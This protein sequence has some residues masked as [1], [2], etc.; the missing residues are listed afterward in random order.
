MRKEKFLVI[1]LL[2]FLINLA[3]V[4]SQ[5]QEFSYLISNS[6]DWRDVYSVMHYSTLTGVGSD[7][8]ASTRHG[9][10]LLGGIS[11][12]NDIRVISSDSRF[13]INYADQIISEGFR[14][15]DEVVMDNANIELVEDLPEIN[16][17]IVVDNTYG[18][19]AISAAPYAVVKKA[20]VFLA[21]R[22]NIDD[23]DAVLSNRE[24]DE[25]M[26]YGF[27]D[28]E[29]RE[30]LEKYDPVVIDNGDRFEDN[31]EIVKKYLELKPSE[32]VTLSNGEFIEKSLMSGNEPILFTGKENVPEQIGEYIKNSDIK[33]GVLV[34]ADLVGTATNIR[35]T[36]GISVIVKFAR[37]ARSPTGAIAAVEG[38][39]LFYLPIPVVK[40]ELH[41]A[42]Y[43]RATSQLELTYKSESNVPVFFKGTITPETESG[44]RQRIGDVDPIFVAPGAYKTVSY[45]DLDFQDEEFSLNVFTL[46]GDSP[47]ALEKVLERRIEVENINV[48]DRCE[49]SIEGIKYSKP[50]DAFVIK[51]KNN[52]EIT[53]YADAEIEKIIIDR[54]EQTLGSLGSVAVAPGKTEKIFIEGELSD[55]DL[56]ENSFVNIIAYYG[57]REDN[58]VKILKGRF[59]LGIETISYATI[60]MIVLILIV[61]ASLVFLIIFWKRRKDDDDL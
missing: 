36:T 35:R 40:L 11:K 55:E 28:R 19:G 34:G 25:V 32:Q 1:V 8:L 48:I 21:N 49:M 18:Y 29:V 52:A 33:V 22:A 59:E 27:V 12:D 47:S 10:L 5:E 16:D 51:I 53:C 57:E 45:P 61:I 4:S 42:K 14:G 20:W 7:F 41:S 24:V 44:E 23:I 56:S 26:I 6:E 17:F 39:D 31:V 2:L 58:L 46:Y 13:V 15:A 3:L 43:N 54:K 38:L 37:G 30:T 50:K 9:P 60:G